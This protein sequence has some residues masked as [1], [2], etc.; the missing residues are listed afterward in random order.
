MLEKC[1][2]VPFFA[3]LLFHNVKLHHVMTGSLPPSCT[4][5]LRSPVIEEHSGLNQ[6]RMA[7]FGH[8][9][10]NAFFVAT[11]APLSQCRRMRSSNA[12]H[13]VV[14]EQ[15]GPAAFS[16]LSHARIS[17]QSAGEKPLQLI[18]TGRIEQVGMPRSDS[19]SGA[20]LLNVFRHK[21]VRRLVLDQAESQR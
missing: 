13:C 17:G 20:S 12:A 7:G 5:A 1:R 14:S 3:Q 6:A 9:H 16:S 18:L 4:L 8:P 11:I 2:H 19:A 10:D 21:M 15:A